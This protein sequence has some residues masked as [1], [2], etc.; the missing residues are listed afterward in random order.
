LLAICLGYLMV[1]VDATIVNV[2]LPSVGRE[3]HTG[4]SALQWV[5]D[6]YT[7]VFAGLLLAGGALGDRLGARRVFDGGL[8]LFTLASAACAAAPSALA[9]IGARAAQ[10]VGAALLVP[11][12]LALLRAT[13]AD[14]AERAQAVGVWGGVAGIGAASGP[15]LGGFLV[16]LLSWR[17]VFVVNVPVGAFALWLGARHLRATGER[18]DGALDPAGQVLGIMTLTLLTT[19]VIEGGARGWT[20]VPASVPLIACVP[21]AV[22][23]ASVQARRRDPMLPLSL[24]RNPTFSGAS[25]VGLA[26]NLGFYGQLFALSLYFQHIRELSPVLT[27]LALLPE[28]A[29]VALASA[30]SGRV[31]ARLGSRVPMLV[32]LLCGTAGF[33]GLIAAGSRTAYP[34]LVAPLVAAGFGMAFTMPAATAA[35]IETAPASRAGIASGVLNAARQAGGAIGVA[36]L[37]TLIARGTFVTGLHEAMGVSAAAFAAGA[38]VTAVAIRPDTRDA[39]VIM[40]AD[41]CN[42][43]TWLGSGERRLARLDARDAGRHGQAAP[44]SDGP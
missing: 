11:S 17:A 27:G 20:S 14:P 22:L 34:V 31:T 16:G 24:F 33:L 36:L 10:G 37:G 23:F 21:V 30:L 26:I 18:S 15:I 40:D 9:L 8:V 38:A 44:A 41:E 25:F 12:S 7:I 3:L 5:L 19:G 1:I 13:Y 43:R 6:A 28:G 2:A 32:G 29:V 39:C 4:V 35:I 42:R